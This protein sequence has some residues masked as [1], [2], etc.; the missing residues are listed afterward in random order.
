METGLTTTCKCRNQSER[1]YMNFMVA[2]INTLG[3]PHTVLL[4]KNGISSHAVAISNLIPLRFL[5]KCFCTSHKM[6]VWLHENSTTVLLADSCSII[7]NSYISGNII[8]SFTNTIC[9][10]LF[11]HIAINLLSLCSDSFTQNYTLKRN[12]YA[13]EY[14]LPPFKIVFNID[15]SIIF[16]FWLLFCYASTCKGTYWQLGLVVLLQT[17]SLKQFVQ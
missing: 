16:V 17:I 11:S 10:A 5:F 2:T 4:K 7:F 13:R 3:E 8:S 12:N 14:N 15:V 6:S 9:P 1:L